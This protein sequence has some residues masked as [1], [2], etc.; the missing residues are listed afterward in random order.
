MLSLFQKN[1][2]AVVVSR[3]GEGL[4]LRDGHVPRQLPV[5]IPEILQSA[6]AKYT[7]GGEGRLLSFTSHSFVLTGNRK[8]LYDALTSKTMDS[9][10]DNAIQLLQTLNFKQDGLSYANKLYN[11]MLPRLKEY[12]YDVWHL[13][14]LLIDHSDTPANIKQEWHDK[15]HDIL[16]KTMVSEI[17]D[18]GYLTFWENVLIKGSI[19][20]RLLVEIFQ[21]SGAYFTAEKSEL[22]KRLRPLPEGF[23][24]R[25][26][27]SF[28]KSN[29]AHRYSELSLNSIVNWNFSAWDIASNIL[30]GKSTKAPEAIESCCRNALVSLNIKN[31]FFNADLKKRKSPLIVV[32]IFQLPETIM[33]DEL[34]TE[35]LGVLVPLLEDGLINTDDNAW[36]ISLSLMENSRIPVSIKTKLKAIYEP[37]VSNDVFFEKFFIREERDHRILTALITA[38]DAVISKAVRMALITNITNALLSD[39]FLHRIPRLVWRAALD[40]MLANTLLE[41][42]AE[43]P[44]ITDGSETNAVTKKAAVMP[45]TNAG[46]E[47]PEVDSRLVEDRLVNTETS[48][49]STALSLRDQHSEGK[50]VELSSWSDLVLFIITQPGFVRSFLTR[51]GDPS[52]LVDLFLMKATADNIGRIEKFWAALVEGLVN[53]LSNVSLFNS[54][55]WVTALKLIKTCE[56]SRCMALKNVCRKRLESE[57]F[58]LDMFNNNSD[59]KIIVTLFETDNLLKENYNELRNSF[60][61][62]IFDMLKPCATSNHSNAP[63][64]FKEMVKYLESVHTS[65]DEAKKTFR[66]AGGA[67]FLEILVDHGSFDASA[68]ASELLASGKEMRTIT[69][70]NLYRHGFTFLVEVLI[71]CARSSGAAEMLPDYLVFLSRIELSEQRGGEP[72]RCMVKA[73]DASIRQL[74][75]EKDIGALKALALSLKQI[76]GRGVVAIEQFQRKECGDI[77]VELKKSRN[78][79][80]IECLVTNLRLDIFP[81]GAIWYYEALVAS[82]PEKIMPGE[83]QAASA[84]SLNLGALWCG[85]HASATTSA[86]A[87]QAVVPKKA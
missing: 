52:V 3:P 26:E 18:E 22:S 31:V 12:D 42:P 25:Q 36:I 72:L 58:F 41:K 66:G 83:G 59:P 69:E 63:Q 21:T 76:S 77:L 82:A 9:H 53:E 75:N 64:L 74:A 55:A 7:R 39:D 45:I 35:K 43:L 27:F 68:C 28:S 70:D 37:I 6:L 65:A 48:N 78:I 4:E 2:S 38:E 19:D 29:E 50:I 20:S 30:K 40:L 47:G 49:N 16:S 32:K 44:T 11:E 14:L 13:I 79:D 61:V 57:T 81:S 84:V 8:K 5:I 71:D 46:L 34:F 60:V 85:L 17:N 80:A 73:L 87:S 51:N 15:C 62:Q 24:W 86:P 1:K 54:S 10:E 33:S 56:E 67:F 23:L